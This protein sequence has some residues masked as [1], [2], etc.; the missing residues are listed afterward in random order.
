MKARQGD[1]VVI[2]ASHVGESTRAGV[3]LEVRGQDGGPPFLVRWADGHT[4]LMYP[5][6]GSVLR[7]LA[8]HEREQVTG[9]TAGT[10]E[11]T[12]RANADRPTGGLVKPT[13]GHVR[14]W[15]VLVSIF[16]SGDNTSASVVLV[17]DAPTR[18]TAR[19]QSHRRNKD[20]SVPEIGDE[21]AVARAL[22]HLADRLLE[23]AAQDIGAV[24]GENV[25]LRP[26]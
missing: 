17:S 12:P 25:V 23:T 21:V 2:A 7:V 15:Q 24:T 13:L 22:R 14:E 8:E 10:P 26:S 19:G 5:G 16:E 18:L 6:P 3:V 4:G 1:H 20:T 9:A 11:E